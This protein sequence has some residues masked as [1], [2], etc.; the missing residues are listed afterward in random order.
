MVHPPDYPYEFYRVSHH[1]YSLSDLWICGIS[2]E[3]VRS[4][5]ALIRHIPAYNGKAGNSPFPVFRFEKHQ[6]E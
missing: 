6:A 5:K 4:C 3:T 1:V 2:D